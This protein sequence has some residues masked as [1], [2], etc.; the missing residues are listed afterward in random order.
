MDTARTFKPNTILLWRQAAE[1]PEARRILELFPSAEVRLIERQRFALSP[2]MSQSQA[3]LAGKRILMIGRTSSFV[4]HFDGSLG[5]S[6]LCCPYYK[7]V[8]LSNG[9]PYFCTYCYLAFV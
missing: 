4:G 5:P 8:P 3:L 2:D 7:L 1:D 9:C 6:V